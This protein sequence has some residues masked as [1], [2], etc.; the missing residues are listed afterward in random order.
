MS[1]T[2]HRLTATS[3][4]LRVALRL[5]ARA[6]ERDR[7]AQVTA[8]VVVSL[9]C[10]LTVASSVVSARR[11]RLAWSTHVNVVALTGDVAAGEQVG[12]GNTER[13]AL[14]VALV[15]QDAATEI[16]TGLRARI[17]LR[18]GTPLTASMLVP[19]DGAVAVP[20]GWRV[21]AIPLDLAMPAVSPGDTVDLVV[22]TTVIVSDARVVSADPLTVAVP[23]S[24]VAQVAAAARVAEL[25]V[26][27]HE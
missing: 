27:A 3:Q 1:G 4:R 22:G 9:V 18:A 20:A 5:C 12:P 6:L 15:A 14:P 23:A 10:T 16:P 21:I 26:A 11:D 24:A 19:A 8:V 25:V 2:R 17:A 7:R 13:I